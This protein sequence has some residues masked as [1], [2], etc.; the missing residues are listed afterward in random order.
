MFMRYC[1][2][3]FLRIKAIHHK[4]ATQCCDEPRNHRQQKEKN[5][6]FLKNIVFFRRPFGR[7]FRRPCKRKKNATLPKHHPATIA[8]TQTRALANSKNIGN[9]KVVRVAAITAN[10]NVL[11]AQ[12]TMLGQLTRR[13]PVQHPLLRCSR[14]ESGMA[15]LN[16]GYRP[17]SSPQ[18]SHGKAWQTEEL[19]QVWCGR[20]YCEK[21]Q[22]TSASNR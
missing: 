20:A 2:L 7:P 21:P 17:Q 13:G 12:R 15:T 6:F 5:M 3:M 4:N 8:P 11:H 1:V 10:A 9:R 19:S 16:E 14:K 18:V 22:S